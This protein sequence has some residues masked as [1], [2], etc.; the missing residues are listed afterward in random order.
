MNTQNERDPR[1]TEAI[2]WMKQEIKRLAVW[3]I[4]CKKSRRLKP[5]EL[6]PEIRERFGIGKWDGGTHEVVRRNKGHITALL[7]LYLAA[8]GKEYRHNVSN[9]AGIYYA[10]KQKEVLEKFPELDQ[11]SAAA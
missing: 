11:L 9:G 7:N 3:Q 1:I 2:R 10:A 6:T 5:K 4:E 8:R